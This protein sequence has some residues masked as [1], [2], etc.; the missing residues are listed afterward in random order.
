MTETTGT[1]VHAA[2]GPVHGG[3][4]P[5]YNYYMAAATSLLRDQAGRRPRT[6][7]KSD[8]IHLYQRFVAPPRFSRARELLQETRTV[9]LD[10]LPGNG[11]RAA[12]LMLLQELPD[13]RGTLHE[14]PDTPDD[15]AACALDVRDVDD[16]DR[17]LLDLSEAEESR[18][19]DV[20]QELLAFRDRLAPLGAH[21]AVVLPHHLAYLLRDDLRHLTAEIGRPSGRRVLA[22]HL[23]CEGI[24]PTAA[25]LGGQ[26]LTTYV[27][28]VP[29]RQVAALA[30]RV[31]RHRDDTSGAAPDG[32]AHWL[33]A[34]LADEHDQ[35]VRVAADVAAADNGRRRA[36]LLALA[37]FQDSPPGTVLHAT[38]SLLRILSHPD[39]GTP[40]LDRTDLY[41]ELTAVRAEVRPDGRARFTLPGYA[42]A[43]RD[44]FW[45]YMPDVRLQLRDWFHACVSAPEVDPSE[46]KAAIPRFAE[47]SLRCRRPE[48]LRWLVER[49]T[50]PDASAGH[51]PDA[52]QILALGL[53]DEQH[54]RYFRQQIYDWSTSTDTSH[55]LGDVL[56]PVCAEAMAPTHPDQ[57]LV[58]L[59]HLARRG[60]G[61]VGARA[62]EAVLALA[63]SDNRLYQLM[64][65][66][67]G[68]H[69]EHH[70]GAIRDSALFLA[71][72]DPVRLIRSERVRGL[73]AQAWS[74]SLRHPD[75]HWA[76]CVFD[77]LGACAR[78]TGH[79]PHIVDVLARACASDTRTAGRLYRVARAWQRSLDQADRADRVEVVD[80]L[81]RA[82]D[83]R[84]GI[85]PYGCTA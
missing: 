3:E 7:S 68:T 13:T 77:W 19:L 81:L 41:A 79:R 4:G 30:D 73:L 6:I 17:L 72:A 2:H 82:I 10:G 52:A 70:R 31:R 36:L 44:H 69:R 38:N 34:A 11:R 33:A 46:R 25:E 71:L 23:R 76:E 54:G 62:Q 5:Q 74:E 43:V 18:Y 59:H 35:A 14:L 50:R 64:L 55:R 56:V 29:L 12:A 84:Q 37:V 78:S 24:E 39:D 75:E 85:E 61:R 26:E 49:W 9:L 45:T 40:R 42:E 15:S 66:R 63:A 22:R 65:S 67:L 27:S 20:Q 16:G 53:A 48:D 8:R 60:R 83:A 47:Q 58:R 51:I 32:F 21:L 57:A 80:R 1:Y 28:R